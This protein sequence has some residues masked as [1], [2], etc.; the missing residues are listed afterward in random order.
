MTSIPASRSARAM[1][2][3]PRS[4][5][6][7]PG[8][9]TT[10]RILRVD[11]GAAMAAILGVR[12]HHEAAPPDRG[13]VIATRP[14]PDA[15]PDDPAVPAGLE[16]PPALVLPPPLQGEPGAARPRAQHLPPLAEQ[17]NVVVARVLDGS[18]PKHRRP[19]DPRVRGGREQARAR[20]HRH[21]PAR[22]GAG[23]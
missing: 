17:L 13:A 21:R 18:P 5:P 4:W 22:G 20:H 9:A 7:S 1:I 11:A 10:T 23:L 19:A 16:P 6:S 2:F 3:A 15:R 14:R 8:F 12:D